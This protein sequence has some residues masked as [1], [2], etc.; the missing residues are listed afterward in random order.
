[1]KEYFAIGVMSGSSLDGIDIAFCKFVLT[2][3]HNWSY[4]ILETECVKYDSKW[5]ILLGDADSLFGKE[6]TRVDYV[7]GHLLGKSIHAFI[8]KYKIKNK[9]DVIGSHGHTIFHSPKDHYT[10]QIGK[11]SAIAAETGLK[12]VSDLRS[13]DVALN[14]EGAPIS[15]IGDLLLFPEYDGYLNLGGIANVS[16]QEDDSIIA[17]DITACNQVFNYLAQKEDSSKK[18]DKEGEIASRGSISESL[19]KELESLSFHKEK[20]PKA[21]SNQY[22]KEEI[23]DCIS[24]SRMSVD[25]KMRTYMEFLVDELKKHIKKGKRILVTGGGAYNTF[26]MER[27][28]EKI[29]AIFSVPKDNLVEYKEAL[30]MAFMG[31]LRIR[32]ENNILAKVTGAKQNSISGA[33]YN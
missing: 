32:Q 29:P 9:I 33:I 28:E 10:L 3:D 11:G 12:V 15:S 30:I 26:L 4:K 22:V 31:I 7:Y 20:Y 2:D 19:L 6:L 5:R 17:Y 18:F 27:I 14:G 24:R 16:M 21:L 13:I 23:I 8:K 1:M 25:N